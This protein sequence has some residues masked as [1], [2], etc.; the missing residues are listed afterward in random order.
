MSRKHPFAG[1][2]H[3]F[4]FDPKYF[5]VEMFLDL[6]R[7]RRSVRK[8]QDRPVEKALVEELV[9]AA[10]RSPSS[11]GKNPWQFIVVDEKDLIEKLSLSKEHGSSFLKSAPLAIVICA[12]D[13]I[14]T[15]VEDCS[16][17][18]ILIQLA[19]ESLGLKSCWIQ[20]RDREHNKI[21]SARDYVAETLNVP[22]NL[23]IEAIVA[24][25]YPDEIK[26]PH[27]EEKLQYDKVWN[28]IYGQ[29]F[30]H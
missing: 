20:I 23:N 18:T 3:H 4:Q 10:I 13:S 29:P 27:K 26:S 30:K 14:D 15:W 21:V 24:V 5:G 2:T 8:Y 1:F 16:I 22:Q 19:A 11:R 7:Q 17:A 25:G 12:D 6:L 9:E 28:N